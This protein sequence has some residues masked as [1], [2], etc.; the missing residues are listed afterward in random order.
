MLKLVQGKAATVRSTPNDDIGQGVLRFLAHHGLSATP[1]NYELGHT[2]LSTPHGLVARAVDALLM[3]GESLTQGEATRLSAS[4]PAQQKPGGEDES[5]ASIRREAIR[6]SEAAAA[7]VQHTAEFG[8]SLEADQETLGQDAGPIGTIVAAMIERS[9]RTEAQ[10]VKAAKTI[11]ALRQEVEV[12]RG[13][14]ARDALT[15]LPNRRGLLAELEKAKT[16]QHASLALCDIDRFKAVTDRYGHVV[17]DRV[18][19]LVASMLTESCAPNLV[20]RWGGEE[21]M[22]IMP[23][24]TC[25]EG[26]AIVEAALHELSGRTIKLRS[27]DEPLGPITFSAGIAALDG[28]GFEDVMIC[29]DRLLYEAKDAGRNRVLAE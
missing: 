8:R 11:E 14:A 13:D 15:D 12:A 16:C 6:L 2:A 10:L 3:S 27:T 29:A 21:F 19:K 24:A 7:A 4:L 9:A 22:I 17:G 20:G 25:S 18:L 26:T 5:R 1:A 28:R 23:D